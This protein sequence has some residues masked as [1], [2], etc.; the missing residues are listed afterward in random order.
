VEFTHLLI[1]MAR[2]S[3]LEARYVN[4]YVYATSWQPHAWA[5]VHVPGYG[6]LPADATFA[7]VG[8]LDSSHVAINYG[9]DQ[10]TTFDLLLSDDHDITME[11][12]NKVEE[13]L[14]TEDLKG[15]SI[16]IDFDN[17]TYVASV[18]ITN[19]RP[20]YLFGTYTIQMPDGYGAGTAEA[21][22]LEPSQ[23]LRRY[24]GFNH[25]LFDD[26]YTYTVPVRASF[27]DAKAERMVT[28]NGLPN[29]A[30]APAEPP[31]PAAFLLLGLLLTRAFI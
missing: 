12:S 16:S 28:V 3:G 19:E 13:K 23:N 30:K 14:S 20:E 15:A 21:L 6:W 17:E 10:S 18:S 1:S 27:N 5:E 7:Q 22:L 31:C 9:G 2:S 25:S 26:G 11:V 24:Y 8:I 4:G 29:A